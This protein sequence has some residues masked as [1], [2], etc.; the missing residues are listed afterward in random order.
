MTDDDNVV[1]GPWGERDHDF[2]QI[3]FGTPSELGWPP[4]EHFAGL[5]LGQVFRAM[6]IVYDRS[7]LAQRMAYAAARKRRMKV[8]R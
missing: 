6:E 8:V 7:K 3:R 4:P 1:R 2:A 5:A